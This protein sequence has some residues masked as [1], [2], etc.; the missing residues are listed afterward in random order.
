MPERVKEILGLG[1]FFGGFAAAIGVLY[2]LA[3]GFAAVLTAVAN[4]VGT[5]D[6]SGVP[7]F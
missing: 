4:A 5:V 1:L 2:M 6:P 3:Y 7:P